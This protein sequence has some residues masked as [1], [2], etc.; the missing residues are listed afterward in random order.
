MKYSTGIACIAL[1]GLSACDSGKIDL[2]DNRA[3]ALGSGQQPAPCH[4]SNPLRNAYFGDLHVHTAFSADAWHWS[5]RLTPQDA[6]R[7]AFGATVLLPPNDAA[8]VGTRPA[9]IDRP[10]DFAGVTDH[11]EFLA[12]SRMCSDRNANAYDTEFCRDYRQTIG[13]SLSLGAR[14]FSPLSWRNDDL[15]GADGSHCAALSQGV[16]QETIDAAEQ[17][18]DFSDRCERSTFVAYEYSSH[19]MG[20]NLHRNVIF[21]NAIV[22]PNPVSYVEV[23]RE[24]LLWERLQQDCLQSA[25]GCDVLA[26]PHN[27]NLSN[28]RMFSVDYPATR[29]IREQAA[30]A[31]L[32]I[33]LEPL[34]E[35]MQHK[36]DSECRNGL[37][38]VLGAVDELCEFEKFENLVLA[39]QT[40]PAGPDA[41]YEGPLVDW[42]PRAGPACISR[43][44]YVRNALTA[45]LQEARRIGVNPF[46]FGLIASTDTHNALPGSAMEQGYQGHLGIGDDTVSERVS[47]DR[48][49]AGNASNNPGGLIG[50]W[51]EHNS[52]DALFAG[53][54]RKEVFGTSGPRIEPR[55]F[56]GWNYPQQL[57][58]DPELLR[59]AYRAGV[60]M[61]G[62]LPP[63][64]GR[65]APVF[66]AA[67]IADAGTARYPGTPLQRLQIIKGWVDAAGRSNQAVFDVAGD[68]Q[69]AASVNLD[70]CIQSGTGF[71]QLC[72]VWRDP[73]FE[74]EQPAVYYMRAV[75]NPACRYS[76]L[77]CAQL[78]AAER[79]ADCA[80]PQVRRAIQER[81][82]S[83]PIWYQP[84]STSATAA[85]ATADGKIYSHT[86]MRASKSQTRLE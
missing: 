26:I 12:E 3:R 27:A 29:N 82:W 74:P 44:S 18:Q 6:Y 83:S 14:I 37:P 42:L 28:G 78:P 67:A 48:D 59:K 53:M 52:R 8:E 38:D 40:D 11:A 51:A 20:N 77:Q 46:K 24:W 32:R 22:P 17:W 41:C 45:G 49:V 80:L 70:N 30:R 47:Y 16:W 2:S 21:R 10:L 4:S 75:E 79:P 39:A 31:A 62:D 9:Q 68:A 60:A 25:T 58:S 65:G 64:A 63:R 76:A 71:A 54:R 15:C 85:P 56:A 1:L 55:F 84:A 66:V 69:N 36:G 86:P 7:Y 61:G 72:A 50:V 81:A 35:V 33:K 19:R 23:S 57:C 73:Q 34:V 43:L 13:R 5:V